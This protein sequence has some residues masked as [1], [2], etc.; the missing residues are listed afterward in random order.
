MGI[1]LAGL[2]DRSF[3]SLSGGTKQKLSIALA[4]ASEPRLLILDEP[5]GSLDA[6]SRE[7]F[8]EL[9][10]EVDESTT[11]IL[12]SHRLEE[13]RPLVDRVLFLEEGRLIYDGAAG[14]FLDASNAGVLEIWTHGD[15]ADGWLRA[16]GFRRTPAGFWQRALGQAEKMKLLPELATLGVAIANINARDNESLDLL[17]ARSSS[18]RG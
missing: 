16:H 9:F 18:R 5:T 11:V 10:D 2:S 14:S 12:C 7:R 13:I 17:G 4:L 6:S 8:F 15:A 3:R 1:D